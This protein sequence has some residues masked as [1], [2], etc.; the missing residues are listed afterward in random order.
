[1]SLKH[2]RNAS[3]CGKCFTTYFISF[4]TLK[5]YKAA[6]FISSLWIKKW[7][8]REVKWGV[9]R[10]PVVAMGLDSSSVQL[11]GHTAKYN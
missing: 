4:L 9:Q 8:L 2:L 7:K 3:H 10:H 5:N 1:M 11:Q 6:A